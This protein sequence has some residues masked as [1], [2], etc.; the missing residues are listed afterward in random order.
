MKLRPYLIWM[1]KGGISQT[2]PRS[3]VSSKS[4]QTSGSDNVLNLASVIEP[5]RGKSAKTGRKQDA[6]SKGV[7]ECNGWGFVGRQIMVGPEKS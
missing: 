4:D 2:G 7:G 3:N 5:L 1:A 6:T